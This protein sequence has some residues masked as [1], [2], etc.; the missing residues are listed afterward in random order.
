MQKRLAIVDY[1]KAF[2]II[3]VIMNHSGLF[4]RWNN[5]FFLLVIDIAVPI[6]MM[7]S[8]YVFARRYWDS[9]IQEMYSPHNILKSL[10][11]YSV[12]MI[13]AVGT[14]VVYMLAKGNAN[15]PQI[16]KKILI[17]RYGQGSYYYYLMIE[18]LIIAPLMLFI[19]Q[20]KKRK[21][22]ILIVTINLL[23]E[24][25]WKYIHLNDS[26]YRILIFRYLTI[27]SSGMMAFFYIEHY[28]DDSDSNAD[29][30]LKNVTLGSVCFVIGIVYKIAPKFGYEYRLFSYDPWGRTSMV[31]TLYIFPILY[32]ILKRFRGIYDSRGLK[33]SGFIR[34]WT[35]W[36]GT[37]K[38]WKSLISHYVCPDDVLPYQTSF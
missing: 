10:I 25:L 6:F 16:C 7:L 9:T 26:I 13:I 3:L 22:F 35:V 32:C 8:G 23:F 20:K 5:T 36:G 34:L 38:D 37:F 11:R 19:I 14:Y 30:T 29:V 17:G 2:G 21:G 24:V 18:F 28:A 1:L 33:T 4:D 27:I 31:S 15:F 12:P